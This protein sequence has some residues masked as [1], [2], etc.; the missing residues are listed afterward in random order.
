[1]A[2]MLT[3][4]TLRDTRP[5]PAAALRFQIPAPVKLA[6]AGTFSVSPDGRHLV[7]GGADAKGTF[8]LWIRSFDTEE[9][10]PLQ[11][12]ESEDINFMPPMIWSPDSRFIAFYSA[13]KIKRVDRS[14]GLP[15]VVCDVPGVGVGGAWN[16]ADVIIVGNT[17]GGLVKCPAGGGAATPVTVLTPLLKDTA[18]MFPAFLP[19]GRHFLYLRVSRID[20]SESGLYLGDLDTAADRQGTDRL[21][22][23]PFGGSYVPG[24]AGAGHVLF[25]R[26]S[27]LMALPFDADSR[28][29]AGE[30][31]LLAN[32][33]G[34]F[35]DGAS[36][37][38][39]TSTLVYRGGTQ[40][41]QLTWLDRDGA[42]TGLVG[43]PAELGGAALSP[44]ATRVIMWRQSRLGRS[45]REVWLVDVLRHT[46]TPFATDPEVDIPAWS[47]DGRD[48]YFA[49]GVRGASIN[50]KP[51]D[52]SRPMETLLR[53]GGSEGPI[54]LA[55]A[56]LSATPDGR[57]LVFAAESDARGIDLWLLP[58]AAGAQAVPLLQ[59][60]ADQIDGRV[61]PDGHWLAY[62]SNESG[63]N[64][65]FL[66]PLTTDPVTGFPVPGA[67]L[68]VSRGGGISPRWTK[69]GLELFYQTRAGAAMAVT[70][71][72]TSAGPPRELF[73]APGIQTAWSVSADGQRFLVAAPSR[74][75][76]PAFTVMVNWQS[77]L[78]H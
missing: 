55:G 61:S 52:G 5:P 70:V 13:G 56:G 53:K 72:T 63:T 29:A 6:E 36:F 19:D 66:R 38:A 14:G 9:T 2:G 42:V 59:Q 27:A 48:V 20:P 37:T 41:Y 28:V 47:A 65:V 50:R 57:F 15:R 74:Q 17:G 30:A 39:S 77:T 3:L 21:V 78:K 62:V 69:N 54:Y 68:L 7:F 1:M 24:L 76:A 32:G 40:E 18:H 4:A 12:T 16:S 73:R 34:F 64:E 51:A 44:D 60:D 49:L 11:G 67:G 10:T 8:R 71:D 58:L 75:S 25:V 22:A 45:S 23:T 46:S 31:T 26:D 33:I 35:R 43:E